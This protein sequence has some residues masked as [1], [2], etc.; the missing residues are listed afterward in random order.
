MGIGKDFTLLQ[1]YNSEVQSSVFDGGK[2]MVGIQRYEKYLKLCR[3]DK[4][5][6]RLT[7]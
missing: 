7:L 5:F 4:Q 6:M 3:K 1:Q 2:N